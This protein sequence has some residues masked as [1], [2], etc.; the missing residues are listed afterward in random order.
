MVGLK[1][2]FGSVAKGSVVCLMAICRLPCEMINVIA[3]E[4]RGNEAG[5][6]PV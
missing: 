6:A 4:P 1:T 2:M 5:F 3:L